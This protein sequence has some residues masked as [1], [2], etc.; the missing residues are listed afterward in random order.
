MAAACDISDSQGPAD[1]GDHTSEGPLAMWS[2]QGDQVITTTN[3]GEA[4]SDVKS[5]HVVV[6]VQPEEKSHRSAVYKERRSGRIP[7]RKRNVP[8]KFRDY[9][10]P[11]LVDEENEE[12]AEENFTPEEE[13]RS[14]SLVKRSA[15]TS[16]R[17]RGR[18]RKLP[19]YDT[20]VAQE[21]ITL[22]PNAV[23]SLGMGNED[24]SIV[25]IQQGL[26]GEDIILQTDGGQVLT[27]TL[28]TDQTTNPPTDGQVLTGALD[29]GQTSNPPTDGQ[30]LTGALDTGQT[31]NSPQE[32]NTT[33]EA[34]K[35]EGCIVHNSTDNKLQ[36]DEEVSSRTEEEA[37]ETGGEG[38][39]VD[40]NI[41]QE[42]K[43]ESSEA[44]EWE[45]E[46]QSENVPVE[47]DVKSSQKPRTV[48]LN[49]KPRR[50]GKKNNV[51]MVYSCGV[52][53][54]K[55]SSKGIKP[56]Q[57]NFCQNK[58]SS[59]VSLQ[60]HMSRHTD[61]KPHQCHICQRNFR[62]ISCL[63]RHLVTHSSDTPF[64][65]NLC[66][67]KFSQ[68][69]YLRSHM[70][71][72][73]GERPFKCKLCDKAFAHQSDLNR[74]KIVHSGE[75]PYECEVCGT[76]F[77]DPSSKRRHEREHV[78]TK[79]YVCQLCYES[80]KRAGQLK[81]HLS[82]K[83]LHQ[84]DDV[85]VIRTSTGALQF[86]FPNA[87]QSISQQDIAASMLSDHHTLVK[88][89]KIVKLIQDLNT[90]IQNVPINPP[91]HDYSA[92]ESTS[93]LDE[94]RQEEMS[95]D[96]VINDALSKTQGLTSQGREQK[97]QTLPVS[98]F[99]SSQMSE[100]TV[101]TIAEVLDNGHIQT[102]KSEDCVPVEYLHIIEELAPESLEQQ[103]V[104]VHY[105]DS[106]QSTESDQSKQVFSHQNREPETATSSAPDPETSTSSVQDQSSDSTS[107]DYVNHP[108]FSSQAYYNWL[109]S[110]TELCKVMPMP[111]DVSLFQ[112]ISQVH[113]HLS[114]VMATPSG[115]VADK[116][117]FKTLMNISKELNTIINEHLFY[118]MQNLDAMEDKE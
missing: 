16:T 53:V 97:V 45:K 80:F 89:K 17:K 68:N 50:A 105:Q 84:K 41:K 92:T 2:V 65:C 77:S 82:R 30:V 88:Q 103:V 42:E 9:R 31:T 15:T 104:E 20:P 86:V 69:M 55:F 40:V 51:V 48:Y 46:S 34:V 36:H 74:H 12:E 58:F 32:Q 14:V 37:G 95:V 90:S 18:P 23:N 76:R 85:Q 7:S 109:C 110:F 8:F 116:E 44:W 4:T 60:E 3:S 118:V 67:R 28:D 102:I 11:D 49:K 6:S 93:V 99:D 79:P 63:R 1:N 21:I 66:G 81:A 19:L 38:I 61:S 94:E 56:F 47:S 107:M 114:D 106:G 29:T 75:K 111:L 100:P 52:C 115:V 62:Q 112:K 10:N 83:H 113:K 39:G 101:V 71:M 70:K 108:D 78:G 73:T 35:S 5:V 96:S 57:C 54:K 43:E 117:N 25:I 24:V 64:A 59:N 22:D 26:E 91:P 33:E 13:F 87:D 27:G 72:H 98:S